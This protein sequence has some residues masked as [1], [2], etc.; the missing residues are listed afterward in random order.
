M[1]VLKIMP[2]NFKNV[3]DGFF[4]SGGFLLLMP[5]LSF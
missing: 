3:D 2:D 4:I 1:D 5:Q